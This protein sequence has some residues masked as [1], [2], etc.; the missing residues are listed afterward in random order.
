MDGRYLYKKINEL[1]EKQGM[2]YYE[3]SKRTGID[4]SV[5]SVWKNKGSLPN[6]NHLEEVCDALGYSLGAI[7]DDFSPNTLRK[8]ELDFIMRLRALPLDK[9][10]QLYNKIN[11][12]LDVELAQNA[13]Q[14]S[15]EQF[16]KPTD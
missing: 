16:I 6:I 4:Q 10:N 8:T 5:F 15:A 3:L 12:Y 7:L 11:L 13:K 1:C 2:S 14:D 9:Q